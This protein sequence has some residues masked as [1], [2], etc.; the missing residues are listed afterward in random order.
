MFVQFGLRIHCFATCCFAAT[1]LTVIQASPDSGSN[2]FRFFVDH[3]PF[4]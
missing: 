2:T 3:L 4:K 1:A